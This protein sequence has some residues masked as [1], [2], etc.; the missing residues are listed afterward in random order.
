ME[1]VIYKD[2]NNKANPNNPTLTNEY[3]VFQALDNLLLTNIGERLFLPEFGCKLEELLFQPIDE[4]T[5]FEIKHYII[6]AVRRWE[7]RVELIST[8]V[9][10]KPD[11]NAYE[12]RL[13]FKIVGLEGEYKWER[14]IQR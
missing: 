9:I 5:A 4:I 13:I 8:E 7:Q 2:L 1:K 3:A 6:E 12:I 10:P 14:I 11:D